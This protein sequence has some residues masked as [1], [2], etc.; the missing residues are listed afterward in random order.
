[1]KIP[2]GIPPALHK[3]IRTGGL[4]GQ[5]NK[6]AGH[7][8]IIGAYTHKEAITYKV[9]LHHSPS[10]QE[11]IEVVLDAKLPPKSGGILVGS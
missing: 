4:L 9:K 10:Y 6:F 7:Y 3:L 1:M 5:R 11:L 8:E 2:N